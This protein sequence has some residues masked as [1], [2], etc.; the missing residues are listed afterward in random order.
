MAVG[1]ADGGSAADTDS[2]EFCPRRRWERPASGVCPDRS[3]V[4]EA[5]P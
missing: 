4:T 5:W 1:V 2:W 3:A